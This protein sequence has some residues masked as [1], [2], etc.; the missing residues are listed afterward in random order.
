MHEDQPIPTKLKLSSL[1]AATVFCYIYGD[2]FGLY[3]PPA[4]EQARNG[5]M[6]PL[7]PATDGVLI[8]VAM[9]M[10]IPSVMVALVLFLPPRLCKWLCVALGLVYTA[11][12]AISMPGS[13]PFYLV[14]GFIEMALTL[15]IAVVAFRWPKAQSGLARDGG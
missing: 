12:M 8:G 10:A 5:V 2:Y 3:V 7:G 11:I 9:M 14:L 15:S 6:G 13:A 4:I 1:W